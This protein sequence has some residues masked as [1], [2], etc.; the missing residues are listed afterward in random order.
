ML[1]ITLSVDLGITGDWITNLGPF[2]SFCRIHFT[3]KKKK[4]ENI[5]AD[6]IL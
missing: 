3:I 1:D 6:S 5:R 4:K 2:H